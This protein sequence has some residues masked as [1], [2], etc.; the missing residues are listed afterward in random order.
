MKT[1]AIVTV[2]VLAAIFVAAFVVALIGA[3]PK[4]KLHTAPLFNWEKNRKIIIITVAVTV[5]F[6]TIP[7]GLCPVW[8]GENPAHRDQYEQIT[9]AFLQGQ[10]HFL[11]EPGEE[12]ALMENPYDPYAR[13][14][15]GF[16][17]KWDHAYYNGHYYMY[18][19]VVPVFLTF[20]P[21]RVITGTALT[22]YHATQLFTAAFIIGL[23]ALFYQLARKFFKDISLGMYLF[24][25][26]AFSAMSV[27]CATATPALYCT[28]VTA[29]MATMVGGM[30]FW[31]RALWDSKNRK[32]AVLFAAVGSF[33]GALSFG[34]RPT[35]AMGNLI[36]LP[37]MF[38]YLK[39]HKWENKW[40]D[41]IAFL[42]PYIVVGI[43]LMVY[44]YVR[45]DSILEFGQSYQ[46]TSVD[47]RNLPSVFNAPTME[48]KLR[49]LVSYVKNGMRYL[50][51]LSSGVEPAQ[52]GTFIAYPILFCIFAGL[53]SRKSRLR[54][55]E[56][57]GW[58]LISLMLL[59]PVVILVLDV[60]GSP[61]VFPRY[62]MD[63]TWIFAILCYM[64]IGLGY[65]SKINKVFFSSL[66]CFVAM[67][68]TLVSVWL[69]FYPNDLNFTVYYQDEIR[70]F[71]NGLF[72]F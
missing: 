20:L 16:Y 45:F 22:T 49:L 12:L 63:T 60:L 3:R 43:A 32:Q 42:S 10:L 65:R 7:M 33:L 6:F 1:E 70:E 24:L 9:E 66:I 11:Y 72:A 36:I 50:F 39:E 58:L 53:I 31:M 26:V 38:H 35:I 27:W 15:E 64:F 25:S 34:C 13:Q 44:N 67:A 5:L 17:F 52:V 23:F 18:F 14:A 59:T 19:G 68:T 40:K 57:N 41:A 55:K 48:E 56:E 28:A 71:F 54:I 2:A 8:N 29:A 4:S 69:V 30:Y 46:L 51:R 21:Y 47:V 62:R 61:D 37:L